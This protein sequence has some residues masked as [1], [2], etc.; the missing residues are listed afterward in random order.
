MT[1]QWEAKPRGSDSIDQGTEITGS[2]IT[3][4]ITWK[5]QRQEKRKEKKANILASIQQIGLMFMLIIKNV[6]NF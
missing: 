2:A 6:M 1:L 4:S 3:K 5:K